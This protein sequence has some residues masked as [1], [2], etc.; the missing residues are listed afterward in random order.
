MSPV[1]LP[2][3]FCVLLL[4]YRRCQCDCIIF[5][6]EP[7][8]CICT[9][10]QCITTCRMSS[11]SDVSASNSTA[12]ATE[13]KCTLNSNQVNTFSLSR[14]SLR[15]P[16]HPTLASQTKPPSCN[17]TWA[18]SIFWWCCIPSLSLWVVLLYP[19]PP[20]WCN[21]L[22]ISVCAVLL[23]LVPMSSPSSFGVVWCGC[24]LLGGAAFSLLL[25]F[26]VTVQVTRI[27]VKEK[28]KEKRRQGQGTFLKYFSASKKKEKKEKNGKSSCFTKKQKH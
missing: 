14:H 9:F 17:K 25:Y 22:P 20:G 8:D 6:L 27:Q 12:E 3:S 5:C 15:Y 26:D 1:S 18:S 16:Y 4:V 19:P 2:R 13:Q 24:L 23:W 11:G 10:S 7:E 28:V 21:F